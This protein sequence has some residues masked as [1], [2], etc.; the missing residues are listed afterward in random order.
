M[1]ISSPERE[2]LAA[3]LGM[4]GS[5][6]AGERDNAARLAEQF[7]HAS[8]MTWAELLQPVT[9]VIPAKP[10]AVPPQPEPS[11]P[12]WTPPPDN[13]RQRWRAAGLGAF[14]AFWAGALYWSVIRPMVWGWG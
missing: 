12:S 11:S 3:I 14:C 10:A 7:R 13:R 5:S 4:L 8:G 9:L 2:R 1:P 6:S